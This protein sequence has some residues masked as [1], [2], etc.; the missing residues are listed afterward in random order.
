MRRSAAHPETEEV[1]RG[2]GRA[3]EA[4]RIRAGLSRDDLAGLAGM[5]R[6]AVLKIEKGERTPSAQSLKKLANA[7]DISTEE[8]LVASWV[9]AEQD[10]DKQ[11][12]RARA[13][14]GSA[15]F[16][17]APTSVRVSAAVAGG[18]IA[19]AGAPVLLGAAAGVTAARFV[20]DRQN[21]RDLEAQRQDLIAEVERR[22]QAVDD[23]AF[24][25]ALLAALPPV[26]P[27]AEQ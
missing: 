11:R 24:L 6:S 27:A 16:T 14:V 10:P 18:L 17:A 21:K 7:L 2:I 12:E 5:S 23:P 9:A 26:E 13:T 25:A 22:L 1:E 15:L 20:H 8:L 19:A 3:L 4:L